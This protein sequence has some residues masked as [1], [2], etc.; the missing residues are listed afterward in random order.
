MALLLDG[1][2]LLLPSPLLLLYILIEWEEEAAPPSLNSLGGEGRTA[3][4]KG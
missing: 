2:L 4:L 1:S 3:G